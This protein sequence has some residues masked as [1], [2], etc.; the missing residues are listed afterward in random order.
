MGRYYA[1]DRDRRW[2]RT[3][4]AW[5]A[6]VQLKGEK[7]S[8]AKNA[9]E[10]AYARGE[11]DEFILPS[12]LGNAL[13][14]TGESEVV[15][16]NF[17][18]DRPR[19]LSKALAKEGFRSFDRGP[20]YEVVKL[21]MMTKYSKEYLGPVVFPPRKPETNLSGYL[22]FTARNERRRSRR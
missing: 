11:S 18:N 15:F 2:E 17:R 19:Q 21:T 10:Q 13:P 12:V 4:K 5:E 7:C 6:L 22:R 1:M 20:G 14:M 9:V 8:D 3:I 16:C